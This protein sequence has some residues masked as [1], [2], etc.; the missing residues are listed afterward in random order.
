MT[1]DTEILTKRLHLKILRQQDSYILSKRISHSISLHQW[2]DWCHCQFNE[3]DAQEFIRA[4]RLNWS[5]GLSYGFGVFARENHLFVGMVAITEIHL[6]SNSATLGYWIA[7]DYQRNGFAKEALDALITFSFE[8]LQLTRL[9]IVCH[10]DNIASHNVALSCGA[11]KEG[12]SRN[13]FIHHNMAKDGLVF[14]VIP[15]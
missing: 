15:D 11:Y 5:K 1:P 14:S 3:Y 12:L 7:D 10:P 2:M 13:R 6:I 9:E 4:N 8:R